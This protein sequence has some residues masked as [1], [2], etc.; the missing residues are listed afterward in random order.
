MPRAASGRREVV[1][2]GERDRTAYNFAMIRRG[3]MRS[4]NHHH[5]HLALAGARTAARI[6]QVLAIKRVWDALGS[7][8]GCLHRKLAVV[9]LRCL[10][11]LLQSPVTPPTFLLLPPRHHSHS[12]YRSAL[13]LPR[14]I[15]SSNSHHL[16]LSQVSFTPGRH[17]HFQPPFTSSEPYLNRYPPLAPRLRPLPQSSPFLQTP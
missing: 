13:S 15:Q 6:L 14:P 4:M 17:G 5:H 8:F 11:S 16:M 9:R 3:R 1:A 12:R 2:D 10:D 7:S